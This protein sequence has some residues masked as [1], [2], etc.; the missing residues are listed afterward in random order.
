MPIAV[1]REQ[2]HGK[3]ARFVYDKVVDRD[4]IVI[5]DNIDELLAATPECEKCKV[6]SSESGVLKMSQLLGRGKA[7]LV[8]FYSMKF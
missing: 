1:Q 6:V 7:C 8:P 5:S 2:I 3:A 4:L